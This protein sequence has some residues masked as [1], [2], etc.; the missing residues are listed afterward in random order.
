MDDNKTQDWILG[1]YFVRWFINTTPTTA[2]SFAPYR[3]VYGQVPRLG[4][5][6]LPMSKE[7]LKDLRTEEELCDYMG[8][9]DLEDSRNWKC[10]IDCLEE[11]RHV[12]WPSKQGEGEGAAASATPIITVPKPKR[13]SRPTQLAREYRGIDPSVAGKATPGPNP[14]KE[15]GKAQGE[16]EGAAAS[17]TPIITVP[18]PKGTSRPTKLA[19]VYPGI[20]PNAAGKAT[21]G[22]KPP[23]EAGKAPSG[24]AT[25]GP[26]PPK[27]A[28]KAP[29]K[30]GDT[31]EFVQNVTT[32]KSVNGEATMEKVNAIKG[33]RGVAVECGYHPQQEEW[34]CVLDL[35]EPISEEQYSGGELPRVSAW[36][37]ELEKAF[38]KDDKVRLVDASGTK[39]VLGSWSHY[40]AR[41]T[42]IKVI[43]C[44]DKSNNKSH[45]YMVDLDNSSCSRGFITGII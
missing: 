34:Y 19:R 9:S 25:P 11:D 42:V 10:F 2:T 38:N 26:K 20:D 17:A 30:E 14:P 31:V 3:L 1:M 40:D 44:V 37:D 29:F 32:I 6:S 7:L 35:S 24:K 18:K 13:T 28:G 39:G 36:A 33:N 43:E 16:G 5:S 21:P 41:G 45:H 22:P 15:A 8:V 27:E 4:I 12:A 23:K